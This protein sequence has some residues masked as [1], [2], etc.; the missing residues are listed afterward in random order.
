M[1]NFDDNDFNFSDDGNFEFETK[2]EKLKKFPLYIK[3][4]ELL[5]TVDALSA[6]MSKEDSDLYS[7]ILR[8][9]AMMIPPKIAGAYGSDN[10]LICMQNASIIR[11]H[12][13]YLVTS[14][15]GLLNFTSTD[16]NYI[17]VMR[18]DLKEFR[19]LFI[20]WVNTFDKL[21]KQ[22]SDTWGLFK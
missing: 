21:N 18:D 4:M 9:S 19:K 22:D 12:A 1:M 8:E 10:W 5:E 3:A 7:A 13:Q 6:S 11:Y 14:T 20:A 15:T 2:L 16:K 17:K